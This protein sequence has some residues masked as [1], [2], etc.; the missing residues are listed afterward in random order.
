MRYC[1][2]HVQVL[3]ANASLLTS[4]YKRSCKREWGIEDQP[5]DVSFL[6]PA[7]YD[8][9]FGDGPPQFCERA[10]IGRDPMEEAPC[11]EIACSRCSR[12][13][14]PI[15]GTWSALLLLASDVLDLQLLHAGLSTI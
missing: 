14:V 15:P 1:N 8:T 6:A 13:Q 5:F 10:P 2:L 3:L 11:M 12:C 9:A 7:G 4:Q